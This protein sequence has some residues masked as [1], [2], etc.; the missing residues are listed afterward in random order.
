MNATIFPEKE[1]HY[2]VLL[3]EI[4]SI[5]TPQYGG[6]FIDCTFGQGGYTKKILEYPKTKVIALDRDPKSIK[7]SS[8]L[9]KIVSNRFHFENI[10]FSNLEA[11]KL[12]KE[13]I[14]SIIFDLGFSYV[15]IRDGTT[16]LSFNSFGDLNMK[17]GQNEF[18][19]KDV[20]HKLDQR[21]LE[22]I[23]K[24]FGGERD[25]KK[26]ASEIVKNRK[27]INI[28]TQGLV[29]IIQYSQKKKNYKI[30]FATKV[31]QSLR[32]FVNKEISELVFGLI[33]AAKIL[34]PGGKI[35]VVTFNS[36]EDQIVKFFFKSLSQKKS[37]SRYMPNI[38]Q[39]DNL[40]KLGNKKPIIPS[41]K[42]LKINP[43]S[44]SAK[45]RY[46]IKQREVKNFEEKILE[47]FNYLLEIENFSKKL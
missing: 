3:D 47:K 12:K 27:K 15:Q 40:F 14:K 7:I 5:I 38:E 25:S 10:K 13:N 1:K 18:S 6:T 22:K 32:I 9:K 24:F 45:L 43:P 11:I 33:S 34:K 31:F 23:F 26:I 16:G 37:I 28:D 8:K 46:V 19:A 21:E 17:M 35:V 39:A 42:E 30:H 2:P 41:S 44:R 36:L 4:I 29:K 20:I